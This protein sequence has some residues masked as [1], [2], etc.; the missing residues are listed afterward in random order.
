MAK[1]LNYLILFLILLGGF[2]VRLYKVDNPVA[3]WHSWRQADTASVSREFV[4]NGIDLLYP[5]Y[6]DVSKVQTGYENA[7]GFRF[8]EFP[9]FNFIHAVFYKASPMVG[10]DVWGRL[11]SVFSAIFATYF[12]YQIGRGQFGNIVGV[13]SAFFFAFLPFNIYFTRVI[14]PDPL[15][16]ALG[17]GS[18]YFFINYVESKK[19]LQLIVSALTFALA[20]LVKPHAIFFA[21]PIVY[22]VLKNFKVR[23]ILANKWLFLALDIV[24]IPFLLW[25]IWM[26]REGLI[27]GIAHWEWAFNGNNIRFR[28]S[29][30]RWIFAER[31]GK[32]IL[33]FWGILP[34]GLGALSGKG[35]TIVHAFLAG[36]VLYVSIFASANVM[37][38]YY[39]TFIVPSIALALAVGTREIWVN[40]SLHP[41]L[42]KLGLLVLITFMFGFSFYE[43]RGNYRINDTGI[44]EAGRV[45]DATLP[46]DA[47]VIAPYNGDTTFL[48]QTKRWGWPIVTTS[49]EKMI[50]MGAEYYISVNLLDKDTVEF[51]NRFVEVAATDK[52]VILDLT[53]EKL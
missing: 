36:T 37:H 53:K 4:E 46:K 26:Y 8:V 24:L 35:I 33:G 17:V 11:I 5:R 47:L 27:R 28:P 43:V 50:D 3:D 34:F 23:E 7:E 29:F 10:F 32:L 13:L 21:L 40:K 18:I 16:V 20:I 1:K 22:L 51:K 30:W 52:Y 19:T 6:H 49:I 31:I 44:L 15:S 41:V 9:L 38:D 12:L 14:L 45:V 48:Y 39:Q 2:L 42:A 25:R